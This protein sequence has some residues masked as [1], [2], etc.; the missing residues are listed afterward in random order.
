MYNILLR[1]RYNTVLNSISEIYSVIFRAF[2]HISWIWWIQSYI[3]FI[4]F[5]I[6]WALP[7]IMTHIRSLPV[8]RREF[9]RSCSHGCGST[10]T[11]SSKSSHRSRHCHIR[12]ST[13]GMTSSCMNLFNRK[14][15]SSY[16]KKNFKSD[17]DWYQSNPEHNTL[18]GD[19]T[20]TFRRI[21]VGWLF[22]ILETYQTRHKHFD[23]RV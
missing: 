8:C 16:I 22:W 19:L 13:T 1:Y 6:Y 18:R 12:S 4:K 23:F 3:M 20:S 9:V 11:T 21:H 7:V 17:S 15:Y 2:I 10:I 5:E 14:R